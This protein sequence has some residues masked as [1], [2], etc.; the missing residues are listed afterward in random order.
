MT[1]GERGLRDLALR[2]ERSAHEGGAWRV[3]GTIGGILL[4]A[5]L[6]VAAYAKLLD[7]VT[8][9]EQIR[10]EGLDVLLSARGVAVVAIGLEVL[11]GLLL[12]FGVR[13][14]KVMVATTALVAFFLFLV[15]RA[16]LAY[17]RG[18]VDEGHACGCFGN[19]IERTPAEAFWQ[20][21]LLLVP[22][23]A[24]AWV[25]RPPS[26]FPVPW[27][28]VTAAG[29]LTAGALVFAG[30]APSLPLDDLATRLRP[31]LNVADVCAGQGEK[32][33]CVLDAIPLLGEGSHLVVLPDLED[34]AFLA[35]VAEFNDH[36]VSG[37]TPLLWML[38]SAPAEK[39]QEFQLRR[40]ASFPLQSAPAI[41]L[42]PLYRRLPRSFLV[43][44]GRIVR[45]WA[46]IP[47]MSEVAA[48]GSG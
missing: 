30:L 27:R 47:P 36:A 39:I 22:A 33:A 23:L 15:G 26:W 35:R 11:L 41:L 18:T 45:T 7:P 5:V 4:G 1:T 10:A 44:D 29:L 12:V 31:G 24:V 13:R 2:Y 42:R 28:R 19:L 21:V 9:S 8:F 3:V 46:S 34:K 16:Y 48:P 25:A 38:S 14:T 32:K 43:Q 17:L 20:D 40:G 37:A 6:L